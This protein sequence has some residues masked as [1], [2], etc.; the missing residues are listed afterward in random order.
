MIYIRKKPKGFGRDSQIEGSLRKKNQ[1]LLI[2]D[3]S[4]DGGSK[5]NFVNALRNAG[6]D[7]TDI[8]VIFFYAAF[9]NSTDLLEDLG[10]KLHYLANWHD[11]LRVAENGKY[12]SNQ[13][14]ADVKKFL[15]DPVSWSAANG[16]KGPE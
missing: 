7:V 9:P 8:F 4:T 15:M 6:A 2:E 1:V 3:L 12:F 11:I 10:V 13:A 14:I 16:G 5:I